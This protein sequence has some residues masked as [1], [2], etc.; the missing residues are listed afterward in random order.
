MLLPL[1]PLV[2]AAAVV[3]KAPKFDPL[4]SFT[5]STE[6]G[7]WV[8]GAAGPLKLAAAALTVTAHGRLDFTWKEEAFVLVRP[9]WYLATSSKVKLVPVAE[10]MEMLMAFCRVRETVWL[11]ADEDWALAAEKAVKRTTVRV[12]IFF[13]VMR[14]LW[15]RVMPV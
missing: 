8:A 5:P 2:S 13:M 12:N 7:I 6:A 14:F 3:D 11:A 10:V 1:D 9:L 15:L 4:L